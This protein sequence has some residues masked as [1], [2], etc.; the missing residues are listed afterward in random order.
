MT[1]RYKCMQCSNICEETAVLSA[2]NPFDATD[3]I[4]GCPSCKSVDS[5]VTACDEPGCTKEASSGW[6]S[7]KG[8]RHTCFEHSD[9]SNK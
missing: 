9:W 7:D 6:P 2:P 3:T 8:Y 5:L 4:V 1:Y